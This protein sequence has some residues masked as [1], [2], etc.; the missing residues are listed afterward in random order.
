[1]LSLQ[2]VLAGTHSSSDM[3]SNMCT[4]H[5]R[6]VLSCKLSAQCSQ[7]SVRS[8]LSCKHAQCTKPQGSPGR[9]A[10]AT[11][12]VSAYSEAECAPLALKNSGIHS[13]YSRAEA[14]A[15]AGGGRMLDCCRCVTASRW[16]AR[17]CCFQS[18][19]TVTDGCRLQLPSRQNAQGMRPSMSMPHIP[20]LQNCK[21][22]TAT[23]H[24]QP[25]PLQQAT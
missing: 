6:S 5:M 14:A 7:C 25:C 1:M 12:N 10:A 13:T 4:Q 9:L 17:W 3:T 2:H 11:A 19:R 20:A 15:A 18:V 24:M 8:V 21:R 16:H 22:A 23:T